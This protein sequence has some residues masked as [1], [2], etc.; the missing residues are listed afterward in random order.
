MA[1]LG[2]AFWPDVFPAKDIVKYAIKSE[3]KGYESVWIPEHYLFRDAFST[4]GA[5]AVATKRIKLATGVVNLYTRHPALIAMSVATVSELSSG[6]AML[7]VGTGVSFWIEEQ[8]GIKMEKPLSTMKEAT[9][10]IRKVLIGEKFTYNG[11]LFTLKDM[12]LGFKPPQADVP[13][14]IA[15][16][17]P[18]ML[19]LA[20]EI[21]DGVI[22]TAGCSL[23]YMKTVIEN[24]KIGA[25]KSGRDPHEIDVVAFLVCSVS[26]DSGA[27]KDATRELA[28]FL[29]SRPDRAELMLAKENFD[30][31]KLNLVKK[32]VQKSHLKRAGAYLTEAMIDSVT[33]AGTPQECRKKIREFRHAHV[34]LPVITLITPA[35]SSVSAAL[36]LI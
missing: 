23:E 15:A 4:L 21:A 28:T 16:V 11:Q 8:M 19:Q 18:K 20:A 22:L 29:L 7:G 1:R 36:D 3:E 10:I 25:E 27:A 30:K 12:K 14:Y 32:Q 26:E 2:V 31:E 34:T 24:I 35:D 33:V 9:Q 17:K 5:I 6:R 13:I